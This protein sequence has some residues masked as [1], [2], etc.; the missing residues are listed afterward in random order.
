M[1]VDS[2]RI[3]ASTGGQVLIVLE[4]PV[5]PTYK[6]LVTSIADLSYFLGAWAFIEAG[7]KLR[8]K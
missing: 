5:S 4:L 7:S 1:I 8:D 2:L 3:G 6:F